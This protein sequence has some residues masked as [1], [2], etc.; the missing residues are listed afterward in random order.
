[1]MDRPKAQKVDLGPVLGPV[2]RPVL[3]LVP[4][5]PLSGL[6]QAGSPGVSAGIGS[7]FKPLQKPGATSNSSRQPVSSSVAVSGLAP[8]CQDRTGPSPSPSLRPVEGHRRPC[9]LDQ[10]NVTWARA[11]PCGHW[12]TSCRLSDFSANP[13][14][15]RGSLDLICKR[16]Q[17]VESNRARLRPAWTGSQVPVP[18]GD[19][20]RTTGT[21]V[22]GAVSGGPVSGRPGTGDCSRAN[23]K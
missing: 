12:R 8:M 19:R 5:R 7:H 6:V 17:Y 22:A 20:S 9:F 1:M 2:L 10:L 14:G 4:A 3:G 23:S 11:G 21:T 15:S 13:C 18:A 16:V